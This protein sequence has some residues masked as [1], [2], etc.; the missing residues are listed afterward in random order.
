MAQLNGKHTIF[1]QCD[2]HTVLLVSSIARVERNSEDKPTI[3]VVVNNG[4]DCE[5]RAAA[6]AGSAGGRKMWCLRELRRSVTRQPWRTPK[7]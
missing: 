4:N 6:A 2:A 3:P 5:G 1:G 7:L